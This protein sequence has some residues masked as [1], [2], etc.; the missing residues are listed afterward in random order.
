[1]VGRK[2]QGKDYGAGGE[3]VFLTGA[4]V[5]KPL[6]PFDDYDGRRLIENCCIEEAKPQWDLAHPP[7]KPARAVRVHVLFTL[8]MFALA[9]AYRL[10]CE[11]EARGKEAVGWQRWRRPLLEQTRDRVIVFAQGHS[12]IF[13]LAAYSL[14]LGVEL[15]DVPPGIGSRQQGLAKY[16]LPARG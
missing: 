13:H 8:R 10:E 14:L 4:S 1:V 16:R 11:R 2:W 6:Q 3:T 15:K 7:Q 9:T 12:G 5:A